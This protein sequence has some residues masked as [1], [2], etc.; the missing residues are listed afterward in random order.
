MKVSDCDSELLDE[1]R[2][3][4][5]TSTEMMELRSHLADCHSCRHAQQVF[6]DFAEEPPA[7]VDDSAE[8]LAMSELASR[9]LAERNGRRA[10]SR[11]GVGRPVRI[12]MMAASLVLM[13][14]TVSAIWLWRKPQAADSA[15]RGWVTAP[16]SR[17]ALF[18]RPSSVAQTAPAPE[19]PVP[20][21][22]PVT[23]EPTGPEAPPLSGNRRPAGV[24]HASP[25]V[26]AALL[27]QHA[28]DARRRGDVA[29]A[30]IWYRR[31]QQ[32]FPTSSS[33]VLSAPSLGG[34]LLETGAVRSALG[35]FDHYLREAPTGVLVPEALYGRGCALRLLGEPA[36][37]LR[38]WRRLVI[39]F[40]DSPYAPLAHRRLADLQ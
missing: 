11:V 6:E 7:L 22:A 35:Q 5:L 18:P 40:P 25:P 4:T 37:E 12:A 23:S 30:I 26:S 10:A 16:N 8:I 15:P 1:A 24:R 19:P 14:G 32:V 20:V 33:A 21:P 2:R 34:L 28:D 29:Q 36:E 9:L 17:R 27:L 31:L 13:A 38:T 39:E 3:R